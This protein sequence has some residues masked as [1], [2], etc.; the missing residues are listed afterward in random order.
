[1]GHLNVHPIYRRWGTVK[2]TIGR[3]R[4][5]QNPATEIVPELFTGHVIVNAFLEVYLKGKYCEILVLE[6]SPVLTQIRRSYL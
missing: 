2:C 1:M 4:G 3:G 6:V 5:V